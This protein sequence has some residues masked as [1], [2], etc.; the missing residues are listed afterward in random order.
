LRI[1]E[2]DRIAFWLLLPPVVLAPL[3]FGSSL[4]AAI[5]FWRVVLGLAVLIAPLNKLRA[6]H[7]KLLGCAAIPVA[8][9]TVVLHE[10]LAEHPWFPP[11]PLWRTASGALGTPLDL[12]ISIARLEPSFAPEPPLVCT[13]S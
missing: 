1:P 13:L 5:A 8:A 7:L 6:S 11:Y 4:S 9:Y 2:R 3:P 12:S 10:P